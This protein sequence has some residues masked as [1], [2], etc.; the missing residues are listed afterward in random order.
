MDTLKDDAAIRSAM[1]RIYQRHSD[2]LIEIA[3]ALRE[4]QSSQSGKQALE[5][6]RDLSDLVELHAFLDRFFISR[7]GIRVLIGHYLEICE[8]TDSTEDTLD[9]KVVGILKLDVSP[10]EVAMAAVQD[11]TYMC[12]RQYG[13]APT[14]EMLGRTDLTFPYVASHLYYI[15]FEV[16]KNSMRAVVEHH[17]VGKPLPDIR[18]VVADGED[19]EDI[20]IKVSDLGGGIPRS[21]MNKIFSYLF[22]TAAPVNLSLDGLE[23]FGKENPLA[24]LG[25][26][27]YGL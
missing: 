4:F 19:N 23:D 11:A 10:G 9:T 18:I 25:Y 3:K 20:A 5:G 17:G 16:I 15:L 12:E 6:G 24:G 27:T 22:T 1:A 26:G 13:D 14:V 7:I 2:T 21:F 8:Q